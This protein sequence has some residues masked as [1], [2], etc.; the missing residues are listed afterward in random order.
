[1][2]IR[3]IQADVNFPW[4]L[5]PGNPVL[6]LTTSWFLLYAAS[7]DTYRADDSNTEHALSLGCPVE[8]EDS[9]FGFSP[10]VLLQHT[11]IPGISHASRGLFQKSNLVRDT[12]LCWESPHCSVSLEFLLSKNYNFQWSSL[13][14]NSSVEISSVFLSY[15][16]S[17]L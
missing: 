1:M 12:R 7:F 14:V 3:G 9:C 11:P 6:F 13:L 10:T 4:C 5:S 15:I 16:N 8:M 2:P 17:I